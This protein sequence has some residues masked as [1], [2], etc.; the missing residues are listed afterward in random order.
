M[1]FVIWITSGLNGT[2]S[3]HPDENDYVSCRIIPEPKKR[4]CVSL[5]WR[6]E[7][8]FETRAHDIRLNKKTYEPEYFHPYPSLSLQTALVQKI[9]DDTVHTHK[10]IAC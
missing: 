4:C 9:P 3:C 8:E 2:R 5:S 7:E 10:E 6:A 1:S